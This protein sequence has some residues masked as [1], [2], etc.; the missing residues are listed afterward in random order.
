MPAK[1]NSARACAPSTRIRKNSIKKGIGERDIAVTFG[2]V[3]F[4][5]GEWL[6]ADED[7]ILVASRPLL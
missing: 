7:G 5:S 2:G 4:S 1:P 3:T 6:Y